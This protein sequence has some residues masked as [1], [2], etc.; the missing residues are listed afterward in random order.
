LRGSFAL[1]LA[2]ALLSICETL[3]AVLAGSALVTVG[4]FAGHTTASSWVNK[5]A[6]DGRAIAS[7]QYLTV[8]YIGASLLGWLGGWAWHW[9][10]IAGA[11]IAGTGITGWDGVAV[12]IALA[13]LAAI[14]LA[15]SE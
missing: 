15:P 9:A 10:K 5:R 14:A 6:T 13:A 12:L 4:F 7:A 1:T 8:Y 11:E 2:G 3:P